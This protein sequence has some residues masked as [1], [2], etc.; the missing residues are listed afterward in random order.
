MFGKAFKKSWAFRKELQ[1]MRI[2][3]S[4]VLKIFGL[5]LIDFGFIGHVKFAGFIGFRGGGGF[6][7]EF[8]AQAVKVHWGS[9][10]SLT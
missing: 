3:I 8:R 2:S 4:W 10:Y 9:Q 5:E 1:E 7:L 6:W